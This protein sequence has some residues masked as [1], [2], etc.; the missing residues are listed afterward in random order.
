[1]TIRVAFDYN[2]YASSDCP[3]NFCRQR[4]ASTKVDGNMTSL[5]LHFSTYLG[6]LSPINK[7]KKNQSKYL[8]KIIGEAEYV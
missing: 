1:M 5:L 8:W 4:S 2:T 3:F 6:L 7:C